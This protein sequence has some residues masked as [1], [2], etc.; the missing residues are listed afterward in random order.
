MKLESGTAF[1]LLASTALAADHV[2]S[3]CDHRILA[4]SQQCLADQGVVDLFGSVQSTHLSGSCSGNSNGVTCEEIVPNTI[5]VEL[6]GACEGEDVGGQHVG[7]R[8]YKLECVTTSPVCENNG[9][10]CSTFFDAPLSCWIVPGHAWTTSGSCVGSD[11]ACGSRS[12]LVTSPEKPNCIGKS[13]ECREKA[14]SLADDHEARLK[15]TVEGAI[16]SAVTCT[17]SCTGSCDPPP[18]PPAAA[19][20][21]LAPTD[22]PA[23]APAAP[24]PTDP[25]AAATSV[26]LNV[27]AMTSF[28]LTALVI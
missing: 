20:A 6:Q 23:A 2:R 25:P 13:C 24:A 18:D 16:G 17:T 14:Q 1:L 5:V 22:P 12:H 8:D 9:A 4:L 26:T 19:P 7:L 10:I 28:L 21:A 15:K 3:E 27:V 11:T